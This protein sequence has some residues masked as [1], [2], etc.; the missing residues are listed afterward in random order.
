MIKLAYFIFQ[1]IKGNDKTNENY[2]L[3]FLI[4][5]DFN[6]SLYSYN[7]EPFVNVHFVLVEFGWQ[8]RQSVPSF[9]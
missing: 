4:Q 9:V 8:K 2:F 7:Y 3:G 6:K 5:H 1:P